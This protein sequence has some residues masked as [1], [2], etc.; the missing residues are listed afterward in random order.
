MLLDK[1]AAALLLIGLPLGAATASADEWTRSGPAGTVTRGFDSDSNTRTVERSG[2]GGGT[3]SATATCSA[4]GAVACE[5]TTT[6]T[7]PEGRTVEGSRT[8]IVG[9]LRGRTAGSVTGPEGNTIMRGRR[10]RR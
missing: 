8:S 1:T 5:R 9:P 10:W 6:L 7:G 3:T 2:L 4:N